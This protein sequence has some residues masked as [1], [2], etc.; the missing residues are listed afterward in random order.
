MTTTPDS[1]IPTNFFM[2]VRSLD[3]AID[4]L[5]KTN[6][7]DLAY[8]VHAHQTDIINGLSAELKATRSV[9]LAK[10]LLDSTLTSTLNRLR[11]EG[12]W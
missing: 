9:Q 11:A 5:D 3:H 7:G 2:V 10:E 4:A 12:A 6:D 8:A 1:I